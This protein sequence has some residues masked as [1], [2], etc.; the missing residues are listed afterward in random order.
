ME[1]AP[2][3][4]PSPPPAEPGYR[5][6]EAPG[7][8]TTVHLSLDIIERLLGEVLSGFGAIPRRGAEI[9][10]LLVGRIEGQE[11]RIDH[12]EA[13]PC[14]YRRGP[15][16]LLSENDG[17]AFAEA[18]E[19]WKPVAEKQSYAVGYF[20]SNTRDQFVTA[21]EDRELM[22]KYFPN[23]P[24]VMLLIRP[25]ASRT[26]IAGFVAYENGALGSGPANEFPFR[27][28]ELEGGHPRASRRLTDVKRVADITLD[29][30]AR[31]RGPEIVAKPEVPPI[32]T[33]RKI[34][35]E[36]QPVSVVREPRNETISEAPPKKRRWAWLIACAVVLLIGSAA[37]FT[38]A[39]M[40]MARSEA[41]SAGDPY[42]LALTVSKVDDSLHLRWGQ[43]VQAVQS[44]QRGALEISDGSY[45]KTVEL[46]ESQLHNGS[47]I[48]HN[49]TKQVRFRLIIYDRGGN[50]L[51]ETIEWNQ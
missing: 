28:N 3:S 42:S 25:Y 49:L 34:Y 10:G 9:G 27:R 44:A 39:L 47:V 22:R 31:P 15:S 20:R 17:R 30:P 29:R 5:L 51:A 19:R 41:P 26:S 45:S 11:V 2:A 24:Q 7:G 21:E 48:Y 32:P 33:E 12:F 4:K 1:P 8:S 35:L 6:W 36:P 40:M 14:E 38:S 16:Y 37:G 46:D 23:A 50:A 13:V 18:Y 43:R